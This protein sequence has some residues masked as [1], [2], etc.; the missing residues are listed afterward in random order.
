MIVRLEGIDTAFS[1]KLNTVEFVS[2]LCATPI[3]NPYAGFR[4]TKAMAKVT[5]TKGSQAATTG[6]TRRSRPHYRQIFSSTAQLFYWFCSAAVA[7]KNLS[8]S[9]LVCLSSPSEWSEKICVLRILLVSTSCF[10]F[11]PATSS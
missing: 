2:L 4:M 3:M 11:P 10:L 6:T 7:Q 9:E 1:Q 8:S 5:K